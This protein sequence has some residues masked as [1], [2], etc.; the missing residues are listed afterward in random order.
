MSDSN[1]QHT[2]EYFE[3]HKGEMMISDNQVY[4]FI[5]IALD[6]D[7]YLYVLYDGRRVILSTILS[8]LVA[9][10]GKIDDKDY[11]EMVR[12]SKLNWYSSDMI[13]GAKVADEHYEEVLNH[14]KEH[15]RGI[16]QRVKSGSE[17]L[18]EFVWDFN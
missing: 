18:S 6:P 4:Q 14:V 8:P 7:D 3:K 13:Y 1:R 11:D 9:L 10:K 12:V 16:E 17:M 5:A 2:L 15:K